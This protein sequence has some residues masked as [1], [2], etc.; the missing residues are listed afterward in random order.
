MVNVP[1]GSS[2][3]VEDRTMSIA[4]P[5]A[6]ED[7]IINTISGSVEIFVFLAIMLF[8][9]LAGMFRMPKSIFLSL[10]A[11]FGIMFSVYVGGFYL[12][13]ILLVGF[14]LYGALEKVFK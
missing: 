14:L 12:L 2:K 3:L 1:F 7:F 9:S 8:A 4:N 5:L 6:L 10:L 11:L 13:I